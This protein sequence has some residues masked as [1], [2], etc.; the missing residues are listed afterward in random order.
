MG[1]SEECKVSIKEMWHVKTQ[2]K[3]LRKLGGARRAV[4]IKKST[5]VNTPEFVID[6][7]KFLEASHFTVLGV[8]EE[9]AD[10]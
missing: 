6:H 2:S 10:P 1:A 3:E 9:P 4:E 5:H 7:L 8:D